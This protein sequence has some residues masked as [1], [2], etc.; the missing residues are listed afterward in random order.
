MYRSISF[1]IRGPFMSFHA[2]QLV[3]IICFINSILSTLYVKASFAD[4]ICLHQG[5]SIWSSCCFN[6]SQ[7]VSGPNWLC[8]VNSRL[9]IHVIELMNFMHVFNEIV[10]S[11]HAHTYTQG[12]KIL[13]INALDVVYVSCTGTRDVSRLKA[14]CPRVRL[15][16]SYTLLQYRNTHL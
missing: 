5:P 16:Q 9:A 2:Y 15:I 12:P 6:Q 11:T 3:L 13:L 1:H 10:N 4:C 8:H 14:R 7:Q